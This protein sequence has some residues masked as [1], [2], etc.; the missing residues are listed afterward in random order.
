MALFEVLLAGHGPNKSIIL[1]SAQPRGMFWSAN[2]G[3]N[4]GAGTDASEQITGKLAAVTDEVLL[5]FNVRQI[6]SDGLRTETQILWDEGLEGYDKAT[7]HCS[8]APMPELMAIEDD[9]TH[10]YTDSSAPPT[11]VDDLCNFKAGKLQKAQSGE[12]GFYQ[13]VG[14]IAGVEDATE[15]RFVLQKLDSIKLA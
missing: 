8:V 15:D 3:A 13:V 6:T 1:P 14:L 9:S 12:W 2:T 10:I 7:M 5:G 4:S 11:A